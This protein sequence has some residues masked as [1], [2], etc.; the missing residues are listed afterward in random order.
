[1]GVI[2]PPWITVDW[3]SKCPFNY[4]DHFGDKKILAVVCKIC[5]EDLRRENLYPK[6]GLNPY[7]FDFIIKDA[8]KQ[9]AE[10]VINVGDYSKK[11][12]IDPSY[13]KR[14]SKTSYQLAKEYG[15]NVEKIIKS[16]PDLPEELLMELTD[17]LSHSRHYTQAKIYRA[18]S[19]KVEEAK[20]FI[21][22]DLQDSKTSAFL[23]FI[24]VLRNLQVM[25]KSLEFIKSYEDKK[26]LVEIMNEGLA[27]EGMIIEDFFPDEELVYEE[28]G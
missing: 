10:I 15:D 6:E 23:A 20:S 2:R 26:V 9:L 1:M 11:T 19:S 27:L 8:A 16:P 4:C 22:R 24:A 28:I 12:G 18:I 5:R 25:M 14:T 21:S 13:Q 17:S 3:F 7:A